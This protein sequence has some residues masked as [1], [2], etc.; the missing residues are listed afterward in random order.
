MYFV[1]SYWGCSYYCS[2]ANLR[3]C[4]EKGRK[5]TASICHCHQVRST[6][7]DG[8]VSLPC[9]DKTW[10]TAVERSMYNVID[11]CVCTLFFHRIRSCYQTSSRTTTTDTIPRTP[12]G[13]LRTVR[14]P[15]PCLVVYFYIKC[16]KYLPWDREFRRNPSLQAVF[17]FSIARATPGVLYGFMAEILFVYEVRLNL[18]LQIYIREWVCLCLAIIF[19]N[20]F[21]R[22]HAACHEWGNFRM[23]IS[24]QVPGGSCYYP[25]RMNIYPVGIGISSSLPG[26]RRASLNI[27]DIMRLY[28][29][30]F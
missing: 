16:K 19:R 14:E 8:S 4:I 18:K 2:V 10:K 1:R 23:C 17:D 9:C 13:F 29:H 24:Y 6:W 22:L 7:Y 11:G 3:E 21:P 28:I 12:Y 26:I 30:V 15:G 25:L 20:I 5:W 27:K